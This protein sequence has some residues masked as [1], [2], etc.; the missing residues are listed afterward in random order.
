MASTSWRS[1]CRSLPRLPRQVSHGKGIANVRKESGSEVWAASTCSK[2]LDFHWKDSPA[3]GGGSVHASQTVNMESSGSM[4]FKLKAEDAK[5]QKAEL[6][7]EDH[8]LDLIDGTA[9]D[10]AVHE[11]RSV[12]KGLS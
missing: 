10:A 6:R 11:R 2:K 5:H 8:H 3:A 7:I 4:R 9:P 12:R 1:L